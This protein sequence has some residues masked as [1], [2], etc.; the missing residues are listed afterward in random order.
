MELVLE[1]KHE[2]RIEFHADGIS[3]AFANMVRRYAVSRVPVLAIDTVTFYDNSSPFWDEYI[4]HRLGLMPI[5]TPADI[6]ESTEVVFSL[7]ASGPKVVHA[8]DMKSSDSGITIAKDKIAIITLGE[9][10][11]L[12]F[13][14]K[15]VIGVGAEHAKFQAGLISYG[16][17]DGKFRF[18]VES[19]YQME[20]SEVLDR[21]CGVIVKDLD[22]VLEG[23]SG[24]P[25]KSEAVPKKKRAPRKKKEK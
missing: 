15:A 1:K 18:F 22:S 19:F 24:K 25:V 17:A 13:E 2:N 3:H 20:P 10:Q 8:G 11:V 7:D 23:I 12:R 5:V 16:D 21:A 14:G 9:G 4:S 6:P